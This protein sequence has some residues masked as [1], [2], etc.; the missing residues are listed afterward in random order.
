M[1]IQANVFANEMSR[2]ELDR[3]MKTIANLGIDVAT[4]ELK[5]E[6]KIRY[7]PETKWIKRNLAATAG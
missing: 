2:R 1:E 4:D 6:L 5:E 7:I 3:M